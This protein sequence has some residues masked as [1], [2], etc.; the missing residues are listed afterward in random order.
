MRDHS[1]KG[2]IVRDHERSNKQLLD[3][4]T[5]PL[6]E[7]TFCELWNE[8]NIIDS[9]NMDWNVAYHV[10]LYAFD[11]DYEFQLVQIAVAIL[12]FCQV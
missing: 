6:D 2:D 7:R 5:K 8:L 4:F 10:Y 1:Q 11:Q 12:Y 3:I 9:H